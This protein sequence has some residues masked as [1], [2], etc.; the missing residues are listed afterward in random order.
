MRCGVFFAKANGNEMGGER[1]RGWTGVCC[2]SPS[3]RRPP[4]SLAGDSRLQTLSKYTCYSFPTRQ[5]G[6]WPDLTE[7]FTHLQPGLSRRYRECF[8]FCR[9]SI[10]LEADKQLRS[11][12]QAPSSSSSSPRLAGA[13]TGGPPDSRCTQANQTSD[14]SPESTPDTI[15]RARSVAPR[16]NT[17]VRM[18]RR[19]W[20]VAREPTSETARSKH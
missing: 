13:T 6:G 10:C 16:M 17:A 9:R 7:L 8:P 1:E 3:L 20:S 5:R 2:N 15:N 11:A 14:A 19:L 18:G 12:R 4:K